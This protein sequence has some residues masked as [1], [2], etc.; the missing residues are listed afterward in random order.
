[1][2]QDES[3]SLIPDIEGD[4]LSIIAEKLAAVSEP[5]QF[6]RRRGATDRYAIQAPAA[7]ADT[8]QDRRVA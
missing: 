8:R 4:S 5:S 3:T 1:M 2:D 6:S 7:E